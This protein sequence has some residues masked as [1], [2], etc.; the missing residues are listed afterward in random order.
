MRCRA[1]AAACRLTLPVPPRESLQIKRD[2]FPVAPE[3][4][5]FSVT[6]DL[7][8]TRC[9]P[10]ILLNGIQVY[11]K[12][13][14][15]L[16]G[17]DTSALFC[18]FDYPKNCSPSL[19]RCVWPSH[20]ILAFCCEFYTGSWYPLNPFGMTLSGSGISLTSRIFWRN[21]GLALDCCTLLASFCCHW[22]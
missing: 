20:E 2:G 3:Q 1:G 15:R 22:S 7:S 9:L 10:E 11:A 17:R 16:P 21:A 18:R 13:F 12:N 4:T 19:W 6:D 8:A 14:R 5:A